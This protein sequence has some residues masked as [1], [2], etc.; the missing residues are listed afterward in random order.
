MNI[1]LLSWCIEECAKF[2]F[3]RHVVK[4]ILELAQ[5]LSTAHWIL[6]TDNNEMLQQWNMN[7]KIYKPTHKNHPCSIW[8]R[9]HV[10][11]YN[12]TAKLAKEL[13]NEYYFRYGKYKKKQHKTEKIIDH[14]MIN[15]PKNWNHSQKQLIGPHKVTE[16]AQAMP[17][18]YK[19]DDVIEAYRNYY[20]GEEKAHLSYWKNREMP[21]WFDIY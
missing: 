9:E 6:D 3:D 18:Q 20:L 17:E 10:N 5:L 13:C 8:I 2:H 19:C 7:E 14:L 4:M 15:I 11:N 21:E 16:P 12:F 1:F